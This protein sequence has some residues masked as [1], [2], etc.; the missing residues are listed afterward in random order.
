MYI[1]IQ[2]SEGALTLWRY[3]DVLW[4]P[5]ILILVSMD[6]GGIYLYTGNKYRGIRL[7]CKEN[8]GRGCNNLPSED[9]LQKMPQ[10]DKS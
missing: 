5:M 7:L 4:S 1:G 6:R 2:I 9:V 10:E 3:R 8:P